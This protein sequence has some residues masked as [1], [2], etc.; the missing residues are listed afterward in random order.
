MNEAARNILFGTFVIVGISLICY[1]LLNI[2]RKHTP[3]QKIV[4][5][6]FTIAGTFTSI[7]LIALFANKSEIGSRLF[8]A[9]ILSPLVCCLITSFII[10]L[11]SKNSTKRSESKKTGLMR[12]LRFVFLIAGCLLI[13]LDALMLLSGTLK[14]SA[15][16]ATSLHKIVYSIAF[17]LPSFIGIILIICGYALHKRVLRITSDSEIIESIGIE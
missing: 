12:A 3:V 16:K 13:S 11:V 17:L 2:Q 6:F 1:Y 8:A 9:F 10:N 7:S 14:I 4:I 5:L 15:D